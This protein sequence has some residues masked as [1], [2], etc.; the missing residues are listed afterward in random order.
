MK[1]LLLCITFITPL[2]LSARNDEVASIGR[3][4][5]DAGCYRADARFEVLQPNSDIPV[6]YE[7][8]L[9][10]APTPSDTLSPCDYLIDWTLHTPA[11]TTSTGFSAYAAGHHY[12]YRDSRLQEYHMTDAAE[13][14]A[15]DGRTD[16]GVQ[17]QAQFVEYLP[18]MLGLRL[19]EMADDS[20]FVMTVDSHADAVTVSGTERVRGYDC[21]EFSYRFDKKSGLPVEIEIDANPGMPSEQILTLRYSPASDTGCPAIDE[22]MLIGR[23]PEVFE[24]Y[25][26]DSFSLMSL[27]GARMPAFESRTADGRRY[28]H[29]SGEPFSCPTVIAVLDSR[30]GHTDEVVEAL[31]SACGQS[32][33]SVSLLL[34]FID[35]DTE[36]I[37]LLSGAGIP[38]ETVLVGARALA[39]DCGVTDTPSIIICRPDG[40]VA[41]VI[42]G[43]NNDMVSDVIQ[44]T[45]MAK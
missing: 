39:R 1:A 20:T 30:V 17:R 42:I 3:R 29:A 27:P 32:P 10:S 35:N 18:Q 19:I 37:S 36:A 38:D 4:L 12:R 24:R 5:A 34:A 31:R 33:V 44:K 40:T 7:L 16:R 6:V 11:G 13:P 9:M 8:S 15:P 23:Y 14:F 25:R 26:H 28:T 41:D 22:T 45:A 2:A 21:R 43:R